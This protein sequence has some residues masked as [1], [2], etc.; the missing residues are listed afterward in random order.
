MFSCGF[1]CLSP[2]VFRAV[3]PHFIHRHSTIAQFY[4]EPF[5]RTMAQGKSLTERAKADFGGYFGG[6]KVFRA[7][8]PYTQ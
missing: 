7:A 1:Y 6:T 5:F 3:L 8:F 4:C 2:K